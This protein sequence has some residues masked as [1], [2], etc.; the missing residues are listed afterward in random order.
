M[1]V[2]AA[3]AAGVGLAGLALR[4]RGRLVRAAG[5][6]RTS[7]WSAVALA[8]VDLDVPPAARRLVLP[9]VPAVPR[10]LLVPSAVAGS[11]GRSA[12]AALAGVVLFALYFL[13]WSLSPGGGGLGFGDVKLAS[14]LGL[15]L[16][17]GRLG[18]RSSRRSGAFL[19]GGLLG[20]S[21]LV[22]RRVGARSRIAVRAV[23]CSPGRWSALVVRLPS[24]AGLVG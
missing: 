3:A 9:S 15:L 24:V 7:A 11:G 10:L 12:R 2:A 14:V 22:T 1:G 5:V 6:P 4:R 17:L 13:L 16:G 21:L 20:W 23:R 18:R 19:V 8:S